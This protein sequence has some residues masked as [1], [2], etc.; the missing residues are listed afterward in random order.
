MITSKKAVTEELL[1]AAFYR[2]LLDIYIFLV[3]NRNLILSVLSHNLLFH[4][5]ILEICILAMFFVETFASLT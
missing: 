3:S 4:S 1:D 5:A 2:T